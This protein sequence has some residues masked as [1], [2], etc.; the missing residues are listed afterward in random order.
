MPAA[1]IAHP[2]LLRRPW[3]ARR[4]IPHLH[5]IAASLTPN[6]QPQVSHVADLSILDSSFLIHDCGVRAIVLAAGESKRMGTPKVFLPDGAGRV[7]ITRVLYTLR[8]AAVSDVTIVTGSLHGAIVRAVS[9]DAP[10]RA[11]IRFARNPDPGRGQLSSLLTGLAVA[12]APGVDAVLVTL[13]DV[14]FVTPNTV[15]AVIDAFRRTRASIVRPVSGERHGHP[16][17]FAKPV[18][19]ELRRADPAQGAQTVLRAHAAAILNLAVDDRGAFED[20]D[21][22]DEYEGALRSGFFAR[23]L[24]PHSPKLY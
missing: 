21:T 14:P 17:L 9:A 23:A 4:G 2:E 11:L 24:D 1:S 15:A 12:D 22:R 3:L 8:A 18:F 19:E 7:F 10:R 13:V 20:F 16:V 5:L 6:L